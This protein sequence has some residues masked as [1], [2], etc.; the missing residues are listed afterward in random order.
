LLSISIVS[1][2]VLDKTFSLFDAQVIFEMALVCGE[3]MPKN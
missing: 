3:M 1:L 2:I